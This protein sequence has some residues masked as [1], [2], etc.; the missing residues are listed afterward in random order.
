FTKRSSKFLGSPCPLCVAIIF[1]T[2][3]RAALFCNCCRSNSASPSV[4]S[5]VYLCPF[6]AIS[7]GVNPEMREF[8]SSFNAH[9]HFV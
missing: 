5:T 4:A 2:S 1:L 9:F 7:F 3:L 8:I 6:L